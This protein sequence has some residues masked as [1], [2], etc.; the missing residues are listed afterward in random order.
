MKNKIILSLV[1]I[2]SLGLFLP[3][4]ADYEEQIPNFT[5]YYWSKTFN[6]SIEAWEYLEVNG[7]LVVHWDL[8]LHSFADIK[9]D[10]IVYWN[11]KVDSYIEVWWRIQVTWNANIWNFADI[12]DWISIWWDF[13]SWTYL[14]LL[15]WNSKVLW[16][17]NIWNFAD[18]SW[19]IYVYKDFFSWTY[20][21]ISDKEK[22]KIVGDFNTKGFADIY[23]KFYLYWKKTV[24]TYYEEDINNYSGLMWKIDPLLKYDLINTKIEEVNNK[25]ILANLE[26]KKY[27]NNKNQIFTE[28]FNYLEELIEDEK[29]DKNIFYKI[30]KDYVKETSNYNKITYTPY[31][32]SDLKIR[33]ERSLNK[34][35]ESNKE[36]IYTLVV[37][38]IDTIVLKL[39]N[40]KQS[41]SVIKKINLLLW[42]KNFIQI[43]LDKINNDDILKEI[44]L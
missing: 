43:K 34:I 24:W 37:K 14:E 16:N 6:H 27:W 32:N 1:L 4:S 9:D 19:T 15:W 2:I 29:F 13:T 21:E 33:L 5:D 22:V 26:S 20:L 8:Y 36:E 17:I 41:N 7:T 28:L 35:P 23:W 25:I 42:I 10:L 44:W 18:I 40:K 39:K 38:K 31:I 12:K 30:K 11:L 3:A